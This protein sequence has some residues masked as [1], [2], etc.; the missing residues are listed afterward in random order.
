VKGLSEYPST[1]LLEREV[2]GV[3]D[4]GENRVLAVTLYLFNDTSV[5]NCGL[6]SC[7]ASTVRYLH[8][9]LQV[10]RNGRNSFLL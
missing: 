3:L 5:F 1:K 6:I 10:G 7:V 4:R 9:L 2:F 8:Y